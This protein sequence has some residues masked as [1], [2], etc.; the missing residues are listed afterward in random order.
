MSSSDYAQI[1]TL[2]HRLEQLAGLCDPAHLVEVLAG[3]ISAAAHPPPGDP[4]ELRALAAA[5]RKAGSDAAPIAT[6]VHNTANQKL[7]AV[8][9]SDVAPGVYTVVGDTG[10]LI[11]MT[12]IAF[13]AAAQALEA[14]ASTVQDLRDR[15]GRLYQRLHEAMHSIGHVKIFGVDLPLPDLTDLVRWCG[16]V[17]ELIRGC[18]AV[19]NEALDAADVFAGRFAD[20]RAMARTAEPVRAGMAPAD[21]VVLADIGAD[22]TTPRHGNAVL[23]AAQLTRLATLM[24]DLP[25]ADRAKLRGMLA[26]A[27]SLLEE[28]YILKA[29]VAG[30]SVADVTSFAGRI[31]GRDSNWLKQ[32]LALNID[33]NTPGDVDFDGIP[34]KQSDPTACGSTAIVVA[35]AM[36]DPVYG[37]SL[38]TD[39]A[40]DGLTAA[41]FAKRFAAA[42]TSTHTLTNDV[43]PK[44]AG[45][46]PWGETNGINHAVPGGDYRTVW[47]DDTD[48]RSAHPALRDAITAVDAGHAVPVL[49][50]PTPGQLSH[51]GE[52]HY[53]LMVGHRDDMIIVYDPAGAVKEISESDFCDGRM[54]GIDPAVTHVNSVTLPARS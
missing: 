39:E 23:S 22:G 52:F 4:G 27:A 44:A 5:F 11:D 35:H 51:D 37:L 7:P 24:K 19:Y 21:A 42:Q 25:P 32:H 41:E 53:V 54:N 16:A 3:A 45:T 50:A 15:H 12:T 14:Y 36:N 49:L 2:I 33:P 9:K 26:D 31:R 13:T 43:W 8:W 29:L 10:D 20:V 18:V 46:S 17:A 28:A 48:G 1:S 47:V 30:H 38:T 34:I 40:G 6:D